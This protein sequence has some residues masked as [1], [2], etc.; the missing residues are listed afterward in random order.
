MSKHNDN[1][2]DV[3]WKWA[4]TYI[5]HHYSLWLR[6]ILYVCPLLFSHLGAAGWNHRYSA[7]L[8]MVL[9]L[10]CVSFVL[11]DTL[12][13]LKEYW[14]DEN[15]LMSVISYFSF[16]IPVYLI[17]PL[18]CLIANL[19]NIIP[20]SRVDH[21]SWTTSLHPRYIV[22]RLQ[23][24]RPETRGVI[25]KPFLFACVVWPVFNSTYRGV[26]FKVLVRS[27]DIHIRITLVANGVASLLWGCFCYLVFIL[28]VSI[29]TQLKLDI[30]FLQKHV[31]KLDMCRR[32]LAASLDEYGSLCHLTAKWMMINICM[33]SLG[34]ATHISWNYMLFSKKIPLSPT[35]ANLNVMI[36]S[37]EIMLLSLT[38][39]AV[40]GMDL[41]HIWDDFRAR[42]CEVRQN[43]IMILHYIKIKSKNCQA[44]KSARFKQTIFNH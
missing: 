39:I 42:V 26:I 27:C 18:I 41:H 24:L 3:E 25:Y 35:T 20:R 6:T 2:N 29:R 36:W 4:L 31:G 17:V 8:S 15:K 23:Y 44:N 28:R 7:H 1:V 22:K 43:K 34:L 13:Y 32:R 9:L 12:S 37:E 38:L 5:F 33:G 11:Y 16:L 30:V 19:R 21:F 40:G 10:A 14:G